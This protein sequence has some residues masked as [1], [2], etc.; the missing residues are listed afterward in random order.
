MDTN[1]K[2]ILGFIAGCFII[3]A[4]FAYLFFVDAK[5]P[6]KYDDFAQCIT[7]SGAKFYGA[8]WCPHCQKQKAEFGKSASKL[9]YIECELSNTEK[10]AAQSQIDQAVKDGR[11]G[12]DQDP[13]TI[14]IYTRTQACTTNKI[15]SYPTWIFADGSRVTGEQTFAE[16]AAK[17]GCVAPA[18]SESATVTPS[19]ASKAQ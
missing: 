6:G 15:E 12:L 9:P 14:G 3:L 19:A 16:L 7:N 18:G 2:T 8:Y 13:N 5:K 17:T 11:L 1:K 4:T 10:K